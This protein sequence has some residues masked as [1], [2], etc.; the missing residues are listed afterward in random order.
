M[1]LRLFYD[2]TAMDDKAVPSHLKADADQPPG[3]Q[4]IEEVAIE[5]QGNYSLCCQQIEFIRS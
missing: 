5:C 4:S 2:F 1:I 3:G